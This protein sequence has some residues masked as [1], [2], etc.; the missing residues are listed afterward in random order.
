MDNDALLWIAASYCL[1]NV[2]QWLISALKMGSSKMGKCNPFSLETL[3]LVI[4][5]GASYSDVVAADA[6]ARSSSLIWQRTRV[7]SSVALFEYSTVEMHWAWNS[8]TVK[9]FCNFSFMEDNSSLIVVSFFSNQWSS[10]LKLVGSVSNIAF[11]SL[12]YLV[13]CARRE[14]LFRFRLFMSPLARCRAGRCIAGASYVKTQ[15]L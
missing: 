12:A 7:M 8:S 4:C 15:A 9:R 13:T 1:Q 10:L 14:D 3:T 5:R 6:S 2:N 11:D